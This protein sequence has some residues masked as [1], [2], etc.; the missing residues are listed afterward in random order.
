VHQIQLL[1]KTAGLAVDDRIHLAIAAD[2][3]RRAAIDE[4]RDYLCEETLALD[5]VLGEPPTGFVVQHVRLDTGTAV[6]GLR[7]VAGR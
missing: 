7:R 2:A 4:H 1:R 3:H 6:V 5:L